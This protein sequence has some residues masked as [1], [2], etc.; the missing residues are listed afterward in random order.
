MLKAK[1]NLIGMM[2]KIYDGEYEDFMKN[3]IGKFY[4]NE[5]KYYEG[6]WLNNKQHGK[7]LIYKEGKEIE[8]IV[9]FGKIIKGK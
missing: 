9:R 6:Q 4:W 1:A 8:G 5:D 3:G 7:G 2:E